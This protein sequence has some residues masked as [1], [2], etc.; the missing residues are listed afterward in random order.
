MFHGNTLK[1]CSARL[2]NT[3]NVIATCDRA[4]LEAF[5]SGIGKAC[6]A[7]P[8]PMSK[9]FGLVS[10]C[11]PRR[12]TCWWVTT[13][14]VSACG[15]APTYSCPSTTCTGT[16]RCGSSPRSSGRRGACV[17]CG[18]SGCVAS[19]A[20]ASASTAC[21]RLQHAAG[22]P[23]APYKEALFALAHPVP[24]RRPLDVDR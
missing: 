16:R 15:R 22:L 12:T 18:R 6:G 8:L 14:G 24:R 20:C 2:A 9:L 1:R 21:L 5:C 10:R 4:A 7:A 19:P 11:A 3:L 17:S 23:P 13:G